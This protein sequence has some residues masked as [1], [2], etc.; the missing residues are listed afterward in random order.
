MDARAS[1]YLALHRTLERGYHGARATLA[2]VGLG[3]LGREVLHQLDAAYHEGTGAYAEPQYNQRGLFAWEKRAI[4]RHFTNCRTLLVTAAGGGREVLA[5]ESLG[6]HVQGYECNPNLRAVG[7]RL[8]AARGSAR[9]LL[10]VERD[11]APP[12]GPEPYHGAMVGWGS[13]TLIRGRATRVAFLRALG[14]QLR[15]QG[16]LLI[17]FWMRGER[18]PR[19]LAWTHQLAQLL[20]PLGSGESVELGDTIAPPFVHYFSAAEI[21]EELTEGGFRVLELSTDDYAHAVAQRA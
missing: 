9:R 7:D 8:L 10:P 6:F 14:Q 11:L 15:P 3:L 2:G 13:Y 20:A 4:E 18:L 19:S 21:R 12:A 17:S 16:P 5:L 1:L